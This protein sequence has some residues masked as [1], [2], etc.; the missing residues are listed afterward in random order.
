MFALCLGRWHADCQRIR[1][2]KSANPSALQGRKKTD[3]IS[4]NVHKIVSY[5]R[6]YF[7]VTGKAV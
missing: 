6:F 1:N 4:I 2:A 5:R 7:S 3:D